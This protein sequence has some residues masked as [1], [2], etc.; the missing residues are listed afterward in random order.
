MMYDT[1]YKKACP[2]CGVTSFVS[3]NV[4]D[5]EAWQSGHLI[6]RALPYLTPTERELLISGICPPCWDS[7]FGQEK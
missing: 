1:I 7:T 4:K 3:A 5:V 6:Q 2:F